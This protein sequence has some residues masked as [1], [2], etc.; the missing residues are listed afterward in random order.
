MPKRKRPDTPEDPGSPQIEVFFTEP[1]LDGGQRYEGLAFY[2]VPAAKAGLFVAQGWAVLAR[3]I[4]KA[5]RLPKTPW[6]RR[7]RSG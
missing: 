7:F 6:Y 3:D 4:D 1:V 5:E 2:V